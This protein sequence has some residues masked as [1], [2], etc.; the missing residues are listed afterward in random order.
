VG[1][2]LMDEEGAPV[3][4]SLADFRKS[5]KYFL[6]DLHGSFPGA[7]GLIVVFLVAAGCQGP[8]SY[9]TSGEETYAATCQTCHGSDGMGVNQAFPP[10]ADSPWL[11]MRDAHLIRLAL[12]G[13]RGPIVVH[14]STYNNVMPPHAFLS[15]AELASVLTYVRSRF[16]T[17]GPITADQVAAERVAFGRGPMWTMREL[18]ATAE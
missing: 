1:Y 18:S 5:M 10:L 12:R 2:F 15:D 4:N 8:P 6:S 14:E 16:G 13:L 7:A 9:G 17:G 3:K 11:Q